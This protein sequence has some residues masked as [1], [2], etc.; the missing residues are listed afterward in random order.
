MSNL[1][2]AAFAGLGEDPRKIALVKELT[3]KTKQGKIRWITKQNAITTTLPRGLE[4]NFV[5]QARLAGGK[6]WQLFTLRDAGGNELIRTA[7]PPLLPFLMSPSPPL[8]TEPSSLD[9]AVDLLFATV[10]KSA[11]DDLDQAISTIKNL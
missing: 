5:T 4:V 9:Q 11:S 1:N 7:P 6:Y 10:T 3:E 8:A 2:L